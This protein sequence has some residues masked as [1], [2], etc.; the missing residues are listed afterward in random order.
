M[1]GRRP[2]HD[3]TH[4]R[5]IS[6][7]E[8][9]P[10][11]AQSSMQSVSSAGAPPFTDDRDTERSPESAKRAELSTMEEGLLPAH[12]QRALSATSISHRTPS[13]AAPHTEH[14]VHSPRQ[15]IQL[16]PR[17]PARITLHFPATQWRRSRST[18]ATTTAPPKKASHGLGRKRQ[19]ES[20]RHI[21]F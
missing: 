3:I 7:V 21:L 18:G 1:I 19:R 4:P 17:V 13:G 6:M 16:P 12:D 8:H 2:P 20:D 10:I 5:A 14:R 11:V 15:R 9:S